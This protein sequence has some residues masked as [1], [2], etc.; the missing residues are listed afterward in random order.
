VIL[1]IE[2]QTVR[3]VADFERLTKNLK[4]SQPLSVRL[5]RE[6]RA[7]YVALGAARG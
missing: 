6:G 2:G 1:E 4:P 7:L 5:E 3:T